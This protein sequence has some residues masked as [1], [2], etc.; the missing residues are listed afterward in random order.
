[1]EGVIGC[2]F[3]QSPHL[4]PIVIARLL[5]H[6]NDKIVEGRRLGGQG[7]GVVFKFQSFA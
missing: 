6:D 3:S 5:D 7:Q 2:Y 4:P 1:M